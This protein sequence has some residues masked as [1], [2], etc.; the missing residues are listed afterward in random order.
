MTL[1][2]AAGAF[3]IGVFLGDRLDA[4]ASSLLLFASC[5]LMSILFLRR[6]GRPALPAVLVLCAALGALRMT[7]AG[8]EA[9]SLT[10][11]HTLRP[12]VVEGISLDDAGSAGAHAM[13]FLLRVE[14]ILWGGEWEDVDGTA[15]VT[16]SPTVQLAGVRDAPYVRYGDRLRLEGA[17]TPPPELDGFDYPAYLSRQGIGSVMS[18]PDV[19][20]LGEGAGA[21]LVSA[22]F[23]VRRHLSE[24]LREFVPEPHSSLG[25]ALLLGMRDTI[26]A[27]IVEDFRSTGTSHLLAISGLHVG[28]LMA[29][30]LGICTRLLGRRGPFYLIAPLLIVWLYAM[31][32]GLSPSVTRASIMGT[33][34]LAALALG[35]PRSILPALG[36]AAAV[37]VGINPNIMWSVSFQLS[38]AAMAGIAALSEP[39]WTI[40]RLKIHL[41]AD[42][43]QASSRLSMLAAPIGVS[44]AAILATMPLTAFYFQQVAVLGLP[45][46][47]A[48]MPMLPFAVALH[49]LTATAGII[50]GPL[51]T[52]FGWLA[53]AASAYIAGVVELAANLPIQPLETGRIAPAL[54]LCYYGAAAGWYAAYRTGA[55]KDIANRIRNLRTDRRARVSATWVMLAAALVWMA[56]LTRGDGQLHVVFGDVGQ[57]DSILILTPSGRQVL[58]DGGPGSTDA[59]R[60]LGQTLPIWDRSLDIMVLSHGHTDHVTGLVDVLRRYDVERVVERETGIVNP[61]FLEWKQAVEQEGAL[62][63]QAE[64]GQVI[65]LGDGVFIEVLGPPKSL[66][67]GAESNV[68]N[69][70]VVLRV[71]YKDVSFLLTGDM[72][73]AAERELLSRLADVRSTVLKVPHHGSRTSSSP[74]FIE[75]TGPSA[76][77]ISVGADNKFGHPHVE[78]LETLRRYVRESSIFQTSEHG[79]IRFSTDGTT[80]HVKTER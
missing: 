39:V 66:L 71:V 7:T 73:A 65:D 15:L 29:L 28:I 6:M 55:L 18:F 27:G 62:V 74:E 57:G 35:R 40:R 14:R 52:V 19:E 5:A 30:T 1:L 60:L 72:F 33:V 54:V 75:R 26:P 11:Y 58:V 36:L 31:M 16:A 63:T 20:S 69:G 48:A 70:S 8:D 41:G 32:A 46:T 23:D 25:Q 37:M 43:G 79:D 17:L 59:T 67:I 2:A 24:S 51:G 78:T 22:L 34:Y 61:N 50:F 9:D 45:T 21:P 47:L 13:R 56:V 49:A 42:G 12:I 4:Q 3:L 64:A 68:N 80:L 38:F 53:W 77:V 10:R 44:A 76:V